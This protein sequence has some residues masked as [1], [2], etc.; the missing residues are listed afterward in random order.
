MSSREASYE[1]MGRVGVSI[2][3]CFERLVLGSVSAA[4]AA[5]AHRSV[6]VVRNKAK[7]T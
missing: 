1:I 4:V 7:I 3:E 6:E 5:R 2:D